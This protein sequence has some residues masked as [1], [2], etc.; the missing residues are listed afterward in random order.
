MKYVRNTLAVA[1]EDVVA[2]SFIDAEVLVEA[3]GDGVPGHF[4][5]HPRLQARDV[6]LRR[7]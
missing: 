4:P 6:S 3:V 5:A 1:E 7:A 2:V